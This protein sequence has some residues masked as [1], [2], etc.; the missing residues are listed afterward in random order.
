M[1]IKNI[2][3]R[4]VN[5]QTTRMADFLYDMQSRVD[6]HHKYEVKFHLLIHQHLFH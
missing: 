5:H 2:Y 4:H 6:D 1:Q 3:P